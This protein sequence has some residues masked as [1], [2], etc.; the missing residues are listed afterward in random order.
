MP[1]HKKG[2]P[3]NNSFW[4]K[5]Y[6]HEDYKDIGCTIVSVALGLEALPCEGNRTNVGE[7]QGVN[8]TKAPGDSPKNDVTYV[9][10]LHTPSG[11][12]CK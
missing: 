1:I 6:Y 12:F 3:G 4:K 7:K 8:A 9:L 2:H 10:R 5:K 11:P